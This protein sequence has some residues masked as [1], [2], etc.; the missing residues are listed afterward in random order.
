MAHDGHKEIGHLIAVADF[1][2]LFIIN[3]NKLTFYVCSPI[4]YESIS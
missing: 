2:I 1:V 3:F 4:I